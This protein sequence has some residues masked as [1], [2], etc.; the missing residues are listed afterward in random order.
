[1]SA[2]SYAQSGRKKRQKVLASGAEVPKHRRSKDTKRWCKGIVGREHVW[3]FEEWRHS[4]S[5]RYA[6]PLTVE[7]CKNCRREKGLVGRRMWRGTHFG[8]AF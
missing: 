7:L 2:D 8:P 5:F 3:T 1:M 4:R 6:A